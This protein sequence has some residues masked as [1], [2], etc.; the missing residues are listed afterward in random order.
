MDRDTDY[1]LRSAYGMFERL[2]TAILKE[3]EKMTPGK[4]FITGALSKTMATV[5]C[6]ATIFPFYYSLADHDLRII[7]NLPLHYG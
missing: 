1:I 6:P 3:G 2:K 5:V 7:G 4:A